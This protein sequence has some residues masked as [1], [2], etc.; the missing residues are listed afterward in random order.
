[1]LLRIFS[2]TKTKTSLIFFFFLI[3]CF[4][5]QKIYDYQDYS[6]TIITENSSFDSHTP[7]DLYQNTTVKGSFKAQHNHL[8]IIGIKFNTHQRINDDYLQFSIKEKGQNDWFYTAKYKVDQFQNNEYFPFGFPEI[9]KSSN[10]TYEIEIKSLN[11]KNYNYLTLSPFSD[12]FIIKYNFTKNYLQNN[13]KEIPSYLLNKSLSY[14]NHLSLYSWIFIFVVPSLLHIFLTT[15]LGHE[16]LKFF[17]K[18]HL[19][20]LPIDQNKKNIY[21]F[22]TSIYTVIVT[23]FLTTLIK[24]HTES[25]EWIIYVVSSI[26]IFLIIL[27]LTIFKKNIS[28]KTY[29]ISLITGY[30]LLISQIVYLV[31]F[32]N[33]LGYNYLIILS[34]SLIPAIFQLK[35]GP[36]SFL[37]TLL[38]ELIIVYSITAYFSLDIDNFSVLSIFIFA[39]LAILLIKVQKILSKSNTINNK[40]VSFSVFLVVVLISIY[41]VNKPIEYHHYSFYLGPVYELNQGKSILID[42]PSQYGYLSIQFLHSLLPNSN[43][44]FTSFHFLNQILFILY[45]ILAF[46]IIYKITKNN[47]LSLLLSITAIFFQ[48]QFSLDSSAL[49]PSTGPLRFG[50]SL[51]IFFF[52]TYF[53]N[54][55]GIIISSL[56]ASVSI[57]WSIETAIYIVPAFIFCLSISSYKQSESIKDFIKK[58]IKKIFIFL[59]STILIFVTIIFKEY[60]YNHSFP[61]ISNYFQFAN[62]YK[63]GFG[64]ELIPFFGNYYPIILIMIFGLILTLSLIKQKQNKLLLPISFI[65]IHNI[66]IFSYFVSRS[67][68]NNIVNI[69]IFFLI[70]LIFF[71]KELAQKIKNKIVYI[72]PFSIF[73][74]IFLYISYL[75]ITKPNRLHYGN[76]DTVRQLELYQNLKSKYHL[77][78][79]N[80]LIISK[81]NDTPIITNNKL[82]T[83]LPLN[84]SLMTILLPDYQQKYL[85]PNLNKLQVGTTIVYSNDLPELMEFLEKNLTLKRIATDS[86]DFFSLYTI[87]SPVP[88]K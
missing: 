37:T 15:K 75:N 85:L 70:E 42:T 78:K 71:Q 44:T 82:N 81:N 1:M 12:D 60:R 73:I 32:V 7:I 59:I 25:S 19:D 52:L 22:L 27:F 84:P 63:E 68:Q 51:L 80:T 9:E 4:I 76:Q 50:L 35:K 20:N 49:A 69:S 77:N 61:P 46:F 48:T 30:L 11:G 21:I 53:P 34:L 72:L 74:V 16:F 86:S 2:S 8:G 58:F 64:S 26:I 31:F 65:T 41:C 24:K 23:T 13:K 3:A 29:K 39:S 17:R 56:I 43:T 67:N 33:Q 62:A 87:S 47:F 66:A 10:K 5:F 79:D 88:K 18:S 55:I 14:L 40:V 38:I 45:Y 28:L 83:R 36:N 54:K 57:F 6:P